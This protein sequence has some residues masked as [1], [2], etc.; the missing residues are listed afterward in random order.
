MTPRVSGP[1]RECAPSAR[2]GMTCYP[3]FADRLRATI[4]AV[5]CPSCACDDTRVVDSRT[6]DDGAAVRRRRHCEACGFRFTT[7]ERADSVPLVVV[8][9][10]GQREEFD[11][12]K[13]CAGV[14]AA[15]KGR[16]IDDDAVGELVAS[17]EDE[18]RQV[19][20]PVASS[21]IGVAVL[22]RLRALDDVAYLRFAS[23]YKDFDAAADFHREI[24]LLT[25]TPP[26]RGDVATA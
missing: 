3:A 6:A 12:S 2:S 8:K 19:G 23:V 20:S 16:G 13:V 11:R 9:A 4:S 17:V 14:R 1:S 24:E 10:D 26:V 5:H 7:Y 18:L 22:E 25:K 15:S 21:R